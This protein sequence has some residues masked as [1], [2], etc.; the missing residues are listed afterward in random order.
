MFDFILII[1][2][3]FFVTFVLDYFG[4]SKLT[5]TMMFKSLQHLASVAVWKRGSYAAAKLKVDRSV[6]LLI[7]RTT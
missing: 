5:V 7:Y 4:G 6:W 2:S 1:I 3:I